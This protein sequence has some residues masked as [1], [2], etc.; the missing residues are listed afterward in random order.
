MNT[1]EQRTKKR[2]RRVRAS[3]YW[4]TVALLLTVIA[5]L[6]GICLK[7][8]LERRN[9]PILGDVYQGMVRVNDGICDV[10][11]TPWEGSVPSGLDGNDF[12]MQDGSPVYLGDDYDT[13]YGIDVSEWQGHIDW[14]AVKK[15]G[16]DFAFVRIGIR[17]TGAAGRLVEDERAITNLTEA[18]AADIRVGAYFFSQATSAEEGAEEARFVLDVLDGMALDLPVMFDWEKVSDETARTYHLDYGT[19]NECAAAFCETIE[20]AGY[21]AGI[22]TNRQLGYYAYQLGELKDYDL[23]VADFNTWPDFYYQFS[24]WQYSDSAACPGI[25]GA[26]DRNLMLTAK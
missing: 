17:G 18:R 10:W 22:Y 25:E 14:K 21:D 23:W 8:V 4:I 5:V 6:G 13:A 15:S 11:I 16:I 2:V 24:V 19:L 20:N 7:L 9:S 12:T 26:V 3:T 1:M